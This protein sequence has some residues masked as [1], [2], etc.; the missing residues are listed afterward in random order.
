MVLTKDSGCKYVSSGTQCS[1]VPP[2]EFAI[3]LTFRMFLLEAGLKP[4]LQSAEFSQWR[5]QSP[6]SLSPFLR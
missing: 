4:N 2:G 3:K 6:M 5:T 1:P